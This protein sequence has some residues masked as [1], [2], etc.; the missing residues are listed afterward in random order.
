MTFYLHVCL[1]V[2]FGEPPWEIRTFA[3]KWPTTNIWNLWWNM[4][5]LSESH[6][7]YSYKSLRLKFYWRN[8]PATV[9]T[10]SAKAMTAPHPTGCS[11]D[12]F[13]QTLCLRKMAA[14][15]V[16]LGLRTGP[17]KLLHEN[18]WKRSD[19]LNGWK[20]V[21]TGVEIQPPNFGICQKKDGLHV[22]KHCETW[23]HVTS[24]PFIQCSIEN[25]TCC[26]QLIWTWT[27]TEHH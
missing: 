26:Q 5:K 13:W 7:N 6:F 2:S 11:L 14:V 25:R 4:G 20:H 17:R 21:D 19:S 16:Y 3:I 10:I 15:R 8:K 22:H 1:P 24:K 23:E 27:H 9:G 12:T 18:E